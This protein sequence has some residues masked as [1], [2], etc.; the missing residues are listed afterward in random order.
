[1]KKPCTCTRT[2]RCAAHAAAYVAAYEA[3]RAARP[4][5]VAAREDA[6]VTRQ[7]AAFRA[8]LNGV[9]VGR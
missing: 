4:A 1:M 8:L 5:D 9:K 6:E 3:A 2:R 7:A